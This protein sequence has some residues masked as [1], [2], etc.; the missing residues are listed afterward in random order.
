MAAATRAAKEEARAAVQ[1]LVAGAA[2]PQGLAALAA[3]LR[4]NP[5][6]VRYEA[7]VS[8]G[9]HAALCGALRAAEQAGRPCADVVE[10]VCDVLLAAPQLPP[11]GVVQQV[12]TVAKVHRG[13]QDHAPLPML[14]DLTR[15]VLNGAPADAGKLIGLADA[16]C[17]ALDEALARHAP[18]GQLAG[19]LDA[20]E[21]L[22]RHHPGAAAAY[23]ARGL[24]AKLVT[25]ARTQAGGHK[26]LVLPLAVLLH[27]LLDR[28]SAD[29]LQE[30]SATSSALDVI[31]ELLAEADPAPQLAAL[32]LLRRYV[33]YGKELD[34]GSL[35]AFLDFFA[36]F[37]GAVSPSRE[38]RAASEHNITMEALC[39]MQELLE[40]DDEATLLALLHT[41]SLYDEDTR[42]VERLVL[43]FLETPVADLRQFGCGLLKRV[44]CMRFKCAACGDVISDTRR[45]CTS[46]RQSYCLKCPRPV[47]Y[48]IE[49]AD[50]RWQMTRDA[51]LRPAVALL[52]AE[53][54]LGA[55]PVV[56]ALMGAIATIYETDME[57]VGAERVDVFHMAGGL[58]QTVPHG[59]GHAELLRSCLVVV[60]H[61]AA[62]T[63]AAPMS[64]G[65]DLVSIL[66]ARIDDFEAADVLP[67]IVA[68]LP[69]ACEAGE[70]SCVLQS[71]PKA[72]AEDPATRSLVA[73]LLCHSLTKSLSP[74]QVRNLSAQSF[75]FTASLMHVLQ[76]C[77]GDVATASWC[78]EG[79][80][81]TV[82]HE[83]NLSAAMQ[84]AALR[85]VLEAL[86]AMMFPDT[87]TVPA[88]EIVK[89]LLLTA[90][91]STPSTPSRTPWKGAHARDEPPRIVLDRTDLHIPPPAP[92]PRHGVKV[93]A[94]GG[95]RP[96]QRAP[97]GH[98]RSVSDSQLLN[99]DTPRPPVPSPHHAATP[100]PKIPLLQ[101]SE[102]RGG[103]PAGPQTARPALAPPMG[104]TPRTPESDGTLALLG[105]GAAPSREK[106]DVFLTAGGVQLLKQFAGADEMLTRQHA[107]LIISAIVEGSV[108]VL[109]GGHGYMADVVAALTALAAPLQGSPYE[110]PVM[111]AFMTLACDDCLRG[112]FTTEAYD[113]VVHGAGS[114]DRTCQTHA[115][116]ALRRLSGT[117]GGPLMLQTTGMVAVRYRG[118]SRRVS[119]HDASLDGLRKQIVRAYPDTS[120]AVRGVGRLTA[121]GKD[122]ATDK[123]LAAFLASGAAPLGID[124]EV[125]AGNTSPAISPLAGGRRAGA[126]AKG[127]KKRRWK[128]GEKIGSGAFGTVHHA[129]DEDTTEQF[130]AKV[131]KIKS[132]KRYFESFMNEIE[133]LS[134]LEH[135]N[136]VRY[137]DTEKRGDKG[138]IILEFMPGGSLLDFRKKFD[139]KIQ[140]QMAAKFIAHALNGLDFLHSHGV[141]HLDVKS[142]N[143][144]VD[145]S[146]VVKVAD[147][148]CGIRFGGDGD[149][150]GSKDGQTTGTLPFMAPEAAIKRRFGPACDIWSLGCTLI[151]MVC[152]GLI[153]CPQGMLPEQFIYAMRREWKDGRTPLDHVK[154]QQHE[155]S[156]P[157]LAFLAR[158]FHFDVGQRASAAQLLADPFIANT[159]KFSLTD[160]SLELDASGKGNRFLEYLNQTHEKIEQ[161]SLDGS[162]STL[163]EN[164]VEDDDLL[165]SELRSVTL[166]DTDFGTL[167]DAPPLP[168]GGGGNVG[169]TTL[170]LT[171]APPT[172]MTT[173]LTN[174]VLPPA[175]PVLKDPPPP[176]SP[177]TGGTASTLPTARSSQTPPA[178]KVPDDIL[179]DESPRVAGPPSGGLGRR[180]NSIQLFMV[181]EHDASDAL[182]TTGA[183][184]APPDVTSDS[185]P[186]TVINQPLIGSAT[187]PATSCFFGMNPVESAVFSDSQGQWNDGTDERWQDGTDTETWQHGHDNMDEMSD[188][189]TST[190]TLLQANASIITTVAAGA[191]AAAAAA[192]VSMHRVESGA[193]L[194]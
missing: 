152:G 67:V 9:G 157:C 134:T 52:T 148:G 147:F 77:A 161:I 164:A 191:P 89:H 103:A 115:V 25:V 172:M 150:A 12:L 110:R 38:P 66:A 81:R 33:A 60:R 176:A 87:L 86:Q 128:L 171:S 105:P 30:V 121:V 47:G 71:L 182:L 10:G 166:G 146:G 125:V 78:V 144:L 49:G 187:V 79:L 113:A 19:V 88:A 155:L 48:S 37:S 55:S 82:A 20:L 142:A 159:N 40:S 27:R 193:S 180:L 90:E 29:Q 106:L 124:V 13:Q 133:L 117:V 22:D 95:R 54:R 130:A 190:A 14:V 181:D 15:R 179:N 168:G 165:L 145:T 73:Q 100:A 42:V 184:T 84:T 91:P 17:A 138:I 158:A 153:W 101:L 173:L 99:S 57:N 149:G 116:T 6:A 72:F 43:P 56:S 50:F 44:A 167:V 53:V 160:S 137:I 51:L 135:E 143:L 183:T 126:S 162:T 119:V 169:D 80:A 65:S 41:K 59:A 141:V 114:L 108:E 63:G 102:A 7:F 175:S 178:G 45:F 174:S 170:F 107:A 156:D 32:R 26:Q 83:T 58:L 136:I 140:E 39:L 163:R 35:A 112:Y 34:Q 5:P 131:C 93:P 111:R 109:R 46:T 92:T 139:N 8:E 98:R 4:G 186:R 76:E 24:A 94:P 21:L 132:D 120:L 129:V 16:L 123:D 151:E 18:A 62:S 127:K 28:A 192:D 68:L 1:G 36:M 97:P 104:Q 11:P 70:E 85:A 61:F 64:V 122:I 96:G 185:T 118:E 74:K 154:E 3:A 75:P 188:T 31:L 194:G 2:T 189:C 177:A 23:K 69:Y